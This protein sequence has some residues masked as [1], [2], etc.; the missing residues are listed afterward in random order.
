MYM[1]A[2]FN[3]RDFTAKRGGTYT[4]DIL[5]MTGTPDKL[6]ADT[7]MRLTTD[8][9][10]LTLTRALSPFISRMARHPPD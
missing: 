8:N 7:G 1:M 3:W 2:A 4:Y 10:T 6:Q 9:V 5:P